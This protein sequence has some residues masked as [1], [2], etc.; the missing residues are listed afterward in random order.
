MLL[1]ELQHRVRNIMAVLRSIATRTA[2]TVAS[3]EEY[4]PVLA[5]RLNTFAC[6]QAL[7]TRHANADVGLATILQAACGSVRD[8]GAGRD[9]VA[10]GGRDDDARDPRT[11]HQCPQIR[12]TVDVRRQGHGA[13]GDRREDGAGLAEL[14][15]ER[16][17][18]ACRSFEL[19]GDFKRDGVPFVFV[20]G[21]D[22]E[23]ISER[24]EDIT[25]LQEPV[26]FRHVIDAL[27]ETLHIPA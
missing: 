16:E 24:F 23:V 20:T 25:R 5:G 22:Q 27:A 7:L 14:R 17:Q 10:Q 4:A 8:G 3:V 9:A 18:R 12:C 11:D 26:G 2:D 21:Y 15:L 13:L 1:A 19:A 6:V